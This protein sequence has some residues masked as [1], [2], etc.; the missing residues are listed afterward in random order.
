MSTAS[1]RRDHDLI[2]KVVKSMEATIQLLQD[3]KTIPESILTQVIDFSKNF[4]DVCHHSKEENSLFPALE[5]AGM[6][7]NMGPI[8]MML[9]D[10]EKSR[11]I[12]TKMENSTQKYLKEN[13]SSDL[14]SN[15]QEYV[16]HITE[17]LWKENNRLFMMAEARLQYVAKQVDSELNEIENSKLKQLGNDRAHYEKIAEDLSKH[18]GT[19]SSSDLSVDWE[20]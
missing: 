9:M 18:L 14:I 11:E 2:E 12:A 1:L 13:D 4:T 3:G 8:A 7:T 15:M 17:H 16:T 10:H 19:N 20:N 6:P 5:K